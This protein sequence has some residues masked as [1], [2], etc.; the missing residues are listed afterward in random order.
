MNRLSQE[1]ENIIYQ[2]ITERLNGAK[3]KLIDY[4]TDD[5]QILDQEKKLYKGKQQ[6]IEY[7]FTTKAPPI[8][9][10]VSKINKHDDGSQYVDLTISVF[11]YV[12]KKTSVYF[13][14]EDNSVKFTKIVIV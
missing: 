7:Y 3:E 10:T 11:G 5:G 4:F 6:L 12:A 1:R 8:M 9:P 2:Y 13:F 14:F